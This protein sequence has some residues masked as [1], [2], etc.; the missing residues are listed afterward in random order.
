MAQRPFIFEVRFSQFTCL[1]LIQIKK[2]TIAENINLGRY[3]GVDTKI[4]N[5][6]EQAGVFLYYS[7]NGLKRFHFNQVF[8]SEAQTIYQK[9]EGGAIEDIPQRLRRQNYRPWKRRT[10][11]SR[12]LLSRIWELGASMV[13]NVKKTIEVERTE[14]YLF[15]V[16]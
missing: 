7:L 6:S 5:A 14:V 3:G 4:E 15:L 9:T 11:L 2:G 1:D 13:E 10:G 16:D 12:W 8:L